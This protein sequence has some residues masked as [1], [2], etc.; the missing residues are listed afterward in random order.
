MYAIIFDEEAINFLN[1]SERS[2]KERIYNKIISTKENPFGFFKR[3]EGRKGYKLRVG[4]YRVIADI[5]SNYKRI[6]VIVIGHRKNVYRN[7]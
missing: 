5:D 6:E 3:L 7:L 1:N 4:D 2:I